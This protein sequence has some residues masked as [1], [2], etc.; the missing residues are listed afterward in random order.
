[1]STELEI[2]IEYLGGLYH[3]G[4]LTFLSKRLDLLVII[5][6]C[7]LEGKQKRESEW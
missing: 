3:I 6:A 4:V 2:L 5:P 1:M 7:G